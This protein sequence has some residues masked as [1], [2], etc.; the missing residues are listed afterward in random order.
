MLMWSDNHMSKRRWGSGYSRL[1]WARLIAK[2]FAWILTLPVL[3]PALAN[4]GGLKVFPEVGPAEPAHV[5]YLV[6]YTA[7]EP[8]NDGDMMYYTHTDYELYSR[9]GR[10]LKNVRNSIVKG[11]EVP[12]KIS[13]PPGRYMVHARSE[14]EGWVA[15]PVR[16]E[17]GRTTVV[18]LE[19]DRRGSRRT[20]NR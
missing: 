10:L 17:Y 12:E 14:Y 20:A 7:T 11:D 1:T 6:V 5:G 8:F 16:I 13:L 2:Y 4:A 9:E 3:A 15:V 19:E 18:N